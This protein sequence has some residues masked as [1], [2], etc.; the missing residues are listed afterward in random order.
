MRHLLTLPLPGYGAPP[1]PSYGQGYD[2]NQ[3]GGYGGPPQ[4]GGYNHGQGEPQYGQPQHQQQQYGQGYD[5]SQQQPWGQGAPPSGDP[6]N[7]YGYTRDPADPNNPQEGE[8]GFMGAVA[9]G[10]GGGFLGHKAG[11][12]IIGGLVGAFLGS[13]GEDAWKDHNKHNK[14]TQGYGNGRY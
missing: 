5:Q 3:Q 13:K 1:A 10:I 9:G 2:Q 4:Q 8:R 12:G 7:P 6:A 14:P 11:H